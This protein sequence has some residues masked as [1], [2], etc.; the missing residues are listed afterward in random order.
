MSLV[1]SDRSAVRISAVLLVLSLCGVCGAGEGARIYVATDGRD[2]WSGRLPAPNAAKTDGPFATLHRARDAVR[3]LKQRDRLEQPVTISVRA[4]TYYLREPLLLGPEDSGTEAYP[5]T[6]AAYPGETVVISGG[7]QVTGEWRS[8]DGKIHQTH[9]PTV[10]AGKWYFRQLRVGDERQTRARYPN[11]DPSG[12]YLKGFH[13][14]SGLAGGFR[15]GLG[16]LQ[17]RGTWLEYDV[18]IPADGEYTFRVYYANS[19]P[20]NTKFFNFTDMSNRTTVAIDGAEPVPVADLTDTGSFYSG[21]RWSRSATL[22]LTAGKHVVRWTNEKGGGLSL[23]AFMLCDDPEYAPAIP[24]SGRPRIS[25]EGKNVVIFQAEKYQRKQGKLVQQM[26]FVDRK[27]PVMHRNF[28]FEPGALKAWPRSPDAEIFVIPEYDW[29][30]ELVRLVHVDEEA[31][32]AQVEGANCTKPFM[33][34][35]RFYAV[36]VLEELDTLGEW[37][38]VR[39]TGMLHYWPKDESFAEKEIVA[40]FLDRVIELRGDRE[41]LVRHIRI[42]G[43]TIR[44]T[45]FTSA[46]R[47]KDTY[48]ADDSAIWLWAAQNCRIARCTF[49]DVGGYGVMLRDASTHNEIVENEIVGAGQGGVYLNGFAQVP[50]KPAPGGQRPAHNRVAGNHIHHCGAFYVHVAGVYLACTEHN[51]VAHN[52]IHDMTRY[53]ISLKQACPG[54]IVEYNEVRRTNLATR[55]TGAIEM[56]CN[57]AGSI[58]RYNLIVDSFGCGFDRRAGRHLCPQDACAIYLDNMSSKIQVIGNI[59][60]RGASGVWLNWGSDNVIEGNIIVDSRDRQLILNCWRDK[61]HWR[62]KGNRVL[63][64]II[65]STNAEL[66]VYWLGGW[67]YSKEI[68]DC[69]GNLVYAGGKEPT[70]GG[71]RASRW[72]AWREAGQDP[73]SLVADPLFVAPDKD[74]YRL[75]PDSP[76]FKLGFKEIDMSRIGLK[77]YERE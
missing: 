63:R 2:A 68:V 20:T 46:E 7:R 62:T 23:L 10:G 16:C 58:V 40:P 59:C 24:A 25:R 65:Y 12:S 72:S 51:V 26:E 39:K 45:T 44:D 50:R 56:A 76:A 75:R 3:E 55:D 67:K 35:N 42:E 77:G 18:E 71:N 1:A 60:V 47:L 21:F 30:S 15:V 74:D 38:L 4:G 19:G 17:E 28:P 52:Y 13:L 33:P 14:V 66:P 43:F 32:M 53:A 69:D 22:S 29:V 49:R 9:L 8:E 48:H 61:K 70:H 36:N 41:S 5:I 27:D 73:D 54:N 57:R 11:A 34:G 31:G 37:C 64:N 6:Y